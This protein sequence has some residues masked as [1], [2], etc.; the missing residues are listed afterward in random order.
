[1][2]FSIVSGRLFREHGRKQVK[3]STKAFCIGLP[4]GASIPTRIARMTGSRQVVAIMFTDM[5]G[6]SALT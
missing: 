3:L 4:G 6:Y 1:V 2:R 5:V